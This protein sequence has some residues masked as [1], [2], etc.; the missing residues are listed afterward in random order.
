M[1]TT[2]EQPKNARH[3]L[4]LRS[5]G[6]RGD[7]RGE[8]RVFKLRRPIAS[9]PLTLTLSPP[10]GDGTAMGGVRF[11]FTKNLK[12]GIAMPGFCQD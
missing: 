2:T 10:R 1:Q 7:G 4:P 3:V 8:V 11:N 9:A 5:L 12:P 6:G